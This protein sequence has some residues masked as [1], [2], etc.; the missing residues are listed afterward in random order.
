MVAAATVFS[1]V[2]G[3]VRDAIFGHVFGDSGVWGSYTIAYM[4]PNLFRRLFG[5]GALSA[6]FIPVYSEA[7][8]SGEEELAQRVGRATL[9]LLVVTLVAVVLVGEGIIAGLGW[10]FGDNPQSAM[11]LVLAAV[12]LPYVLLICVVAL[13]GGMLNARYHFSCPALAPVVLNVFLIVAGMWGTGLVGG[14]LSR[15]IFAVCAGVLLGGLAQLILVIVPLKRKGVSLG[16]LWRP[17]ME[18]ISRI[19]KL[20]SPMI[21]GLAVMQMNALLD[22]LMAYW[23]GGEAGKTLLAI[24]SWKLSYPVG[25]GAPS[26]L[27]HAQRLYN[28]PLGVF[29]IALATAIFP[30]FSRYAGRRDHAGLVDTLVKGLRLVA[31]IGLAA[32]AGLMIVS[33]TAVEFIPGGGLLSLFGVAKGQ[34]GLTAIERTSATLVF[35]SLGIWAYCGVHVVVRG[36]YALQDTMTPVK[37]GAGLVALNIP[38]NLILIWPLGT[39]GLALSTAICAALNLMILTRLLHK[40]ISGLSSSDEGAVSKLEKAPLAGVGAC[41]PK[42][43]LATAI[44]SGAAYG[45]LILARSLVGS[46]VEQSG[47]RLGAAVIAGTVGYY[48]AARLLGCTELR[49]LLGR[50]S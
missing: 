13:L 3:V 29:G 9:W 6:A 43:I 4:V 16:W 47:I 34:F 42:I 36:F 11:T 14:D 25:T 27:Y 20:T 48:L 30:Y 21:L 24:G 7:M 12:V 17:Q 49:E 50:D 23:L 41:L 18:Q 44:M 38:L 2:L 31:F 10:L 1:R 32:S 35:Y 33:R 22:Y 15:K 37:V 26:Y 46:E 40:R 39:A 28:M 45:A 5:E 19:V 8:E